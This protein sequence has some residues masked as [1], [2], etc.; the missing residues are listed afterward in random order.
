MPGIGPMT[1]GSFPGLDTYVYVDTMTY[2]DDPAT[3]EDAVWAE[4][5]RARNVQ[6]EDGP[7]LTKSQYNGANR[8]GAIVGHGDFSGSFEYPRRRGTDTVLDFLETKRKNGQP[9]KLR[10]LDQEITVDGAKGQDV[11][12]YLGKFSE[13]RNGSDDV[14]VTIPFEFGDVYDEDGARIEVTDVTIVIP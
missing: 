3:D 7:E 11:P 1:E 12:V 5:E 9:V 2:D 10:F 4:I 6:I 14:A 8:T 13:T